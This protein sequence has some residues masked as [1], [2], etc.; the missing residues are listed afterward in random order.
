V[1]IPGIVAFLVIRGIVAF[2][3]IQV[4]VAIQ[5]LAG[6]R[7]TL[8]T[9]E[10]VDIRVCPATQVTQEYLAT[11]VYLVIQELVATRVSLDI[12]VFLERVLL[13]RDLGVA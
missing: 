13:G 2:L 4:L 7:E 12:V 6:T 8:V 9:P 1:A 3:V 5:E 10:L 11:P